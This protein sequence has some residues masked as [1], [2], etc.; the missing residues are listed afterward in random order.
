MHHAIGRDTHTHR[1]PTSAGNLGPSEVN[2]PTITANPQV[3][4]VIFLT[5]LVLALEL[6]EHS[7]PINLVAHF[8]HGAFKDPNPDFLVDH[9]GRF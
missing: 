1:P 9:R 6:N 5:R 8:V 3:G 4:V 2:A 7:R